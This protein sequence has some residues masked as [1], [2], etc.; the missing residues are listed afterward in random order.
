MSARDAASPTRATD[1]PAARLR[2]LDREVLDRHALGDRRAL[3]PLYGEA[4]RIRE[5]EGLIDEAAF[6]YTQAYVYAL[7]TG[8]TALSREM[9]GR[10]KHHGRER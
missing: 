8:D 7:E 6:L 10:L 4:G 9:H 1:D 3:A 5:A 2:E